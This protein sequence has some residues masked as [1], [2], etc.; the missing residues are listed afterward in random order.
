MTELF[1][2][3]V[4]RMHPAHLK[5]P[6][7]YLQYILLGYNGDQWDTRT[8]DLAELLFTECDKVQLSECLNTGLT[9][10]FLNKL[11]KIAP[12]LESE[13]LARTVSLVEVQLEHR[14]DPDGYDHPRWGAMRKG[15]KLGPDFDKVCDLVQGR[16]LQFIHRTA[17][18]FIA[19]D[20]DGQVFL[21]KCSIGAREAYVNLIMAN[22]ARIKFGIDHPLRSTPKDGFG[23]ALDTGRVP[24][25]CVLASQAQETISTGSDHQNLLASSLAILCADAGVDAQ[26]PPG[27]TIP[28]ALMMNLRFL[29]DGMSL[30]MACTV[31]LACRLMLFS[32][33][34]SLLQTFS[35]AHQQQVMFLLWLHVASTIKWEAHEPYLDFLSS[36]ST[37]R[38]LQPDAF[39]HEAVDTGK[40]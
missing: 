2:A 28:L 7:P 27:D 23:S 15:R 13:V 36:N 37:L 14:S 35:I 26:S 12:G 30:E 1:A 16:N 8:A 4:K 32:F 40:P 21:K 9:P 19:D 24:R 5:R 18:D 29:P 33:L 6:K 11:T 17:F 10:Y 20:P 3:M 31:S 25:I 34:D 38:D 22:E 39:A